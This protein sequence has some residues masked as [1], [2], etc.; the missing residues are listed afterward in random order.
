MSSVSFADKI[1]L[2]D[3]NDEA[4]QARAALVANAKHDIYIEYFEFGNDDFSLTSLALLR[5]AA[6]R[7]VKVKILMDSMHNALTNAQLAAFLGVAENSKSL[8][9]IEIRL[10]NPLRSLNLYHQTYRNHDKLLNV[11]GEY[12]IV[13]GRNAAEAYFGKSKRMNFKDADALVTGQSAQDSKEYFLKL[14]NTNPEVKKLELYKYSQWQISAPNCNNEQSEVCFA[15]E[16]EILSHRARITALYDQFNAGKAWI[17]AQ[18]LADILA[19]IE[20]VSEI[21]FAYND[22]SREMKKVELKLADQIMESIVANAQKSITITTPY[23]YPTDKELTSLQVL[24]S[25]GVKIKIITNSLASTDTPL[26]HAALLTIEK[27]LADM[28]VELYLFKGPEVLHAKTAIIDDKVAFIGSF[29]FDRRSANLNR[30][31]GIQVGNMKDIKVS[32]FTQELIQFIDSELVANSVLAIKDGKEMDL[33][34]F[35][36]L[37][38]E[39]KREDLERAKKYVGLIKESI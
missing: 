8:E 13:G 32:A 34:A 19:D 15:P 36:A 39:K 37:V 17:K 23:L 30:E 18:P 4:L 38:P 21:K 2:L 10:F 6:L 25:R 5:E 35:D 14:W 29:N 26:V 12:M 24:A 3:N 28:G 22:P 33:E 27:Q 1:K 9:N 11:D 16:R 20:D 31:I 7:G